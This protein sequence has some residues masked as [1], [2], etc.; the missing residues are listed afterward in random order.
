MP[1]D[2]D[3]RRIREKFV[4]KAHDKGAD[5]H[6]VGM[7]TDAMWDN[8]RY[9]NDAIGKVGPKMS[10]GQ[11]VDFFRGVE[12]AG[13]EKKRALEVC[14]LYEGGSPNQICVEAVEEISDVV[15]QQ[16]AKE[17]VERLKP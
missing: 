15:R 9:M 8:Y 16:L 12:L 5:A 6:E 13:Q 4:K 3:I 2:A 7:A 14:G 17:F 11:A 1:V 10:A